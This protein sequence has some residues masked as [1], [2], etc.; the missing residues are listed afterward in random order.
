[1]VFRVPRGLPLPLSLSPSAFGSLLTVLLLSPLASTPSHA[2]DVRYVCKRGEAFG[3]KTF[4]FV[5]VAVTSSGSQKPFLPYAT[6]TG[7]TLEQKCQIVTQRLNEISQAGLLS[8]IT[9]GQSNGNLVI[10]SASSLGGVCETTLYTVYDD[11]VSG[12]KTIA[13]LGEALNPESLKIRGFV[14]YLDVKL[15][16]GLDEVPPSPSCGSGTE[17]SPDGQSCV[18]KPE[19]PVCGEGTQLSDDGKSCVVKPGGSPSNPGDNS[20]V[21]GPGMTL[22]ADGRTCLVSPDAGSGSGSPSPCPAGTEL[23]PAGS[24]VLS[25]A[26]EAACGAGTV[27]GPDGKCVVE[28]PPENPQPSMCSPEWSWTPKGCMPDTCAPWQRPTLN[29]CRTRPTRPSTVVPLIPGRPLMPFIP[30]PN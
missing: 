9:H 7:V 17:P 26:P 4:D 15:A 8:Y 22:S 16:L 27:L 24:C 23:S 6:S 29:G 10:C 3:G 30:R 1:M 2:Q 20:S 5:T 18:P 25:P 13:A 28:T 11:L 19:R 14:S 12:F 21:C